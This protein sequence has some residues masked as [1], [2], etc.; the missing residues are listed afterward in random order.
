MY[1]FSSPRMLPG[2]ALPD[3]PWHCLWAL[4][5]AVLLKALLWIALFR[6]LCVTEVACCALSCDFFDSVLDVNCSSGDVWF[7][8][9][10][11]CNEQ[12]SLWLSEQKSTFQSL[13]EGHLNFAKVQIW[14][15][16]YNPKAGRFLLF[17][18]RKHLS[19]VFLSFH[20]ITSRDW[21]GHTPMPPGMERSPDLVWLV[22]T[23]FLPWRYYTWVTWRKGVGFSCREASPEG[24]ARD[25]HVS[26]VLYL[27]Q[28]LHSR[29]QMD[30]FAGHPSQKLCSTYAFLG[31]S[32]R[33]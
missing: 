9:K 24:R 2:K 19:I 21:K 26:W 17:L 18:F 10:W 32:I 4:L 13:S 1:A 22:A 7:C 14:I 15:G 33:G 23:V 16:D 29:D 6:L 20:G 3:A 30:G 31:I 27:R 12:K 5:S 8:S 28:P 25:C 11:L